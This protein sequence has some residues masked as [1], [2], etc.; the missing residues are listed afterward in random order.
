M[1]R[2][3]GSEALGLFE[4]YNAVY[5][6][7][8]LTE[9][10]VWEEVESWVN[11]LIEE[12]HDLSDYTW[13]EM[14][15]AYIVEAPLSAFS[16]LKADLNRKGLENRVSSFLKGGKP[17]A[18][19]TPATPARST[20]QLS[21]FSGLKADLARKGLENRVS[22]FLK[23]EKP[24]PAAR[25]D[26]T[27]TTATTATTRP[28][29]KPV[30]AAP[31]VSP[32]PNP[33]LAAASS[34]LSG[35]GALAAKPKPQSDIGAMITRSQQRQ[36]AQTP[37]PAA[38]APA[39]PMGGGRER[40]LRSSYEYDAYDLVLEYLLTEGHAD[41]VEEAH[42]VMMEMDAEVIQDIVEA[43][44]DQSDK[45]IDKGVKA[46]YKAQNVLDNQHQGRSKGLNKLPRGEREEKAKRMQGRLKTRRDDLFGERNKREDSKRDEL[47]KMLGL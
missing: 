40:M 24:V 27:A 13:E 14:Y 41:T 1:E 12:G 2:I 25:P 36:A 19:P 32:A 45:Q 15:E 30:T 42:Y 3:T 44:A 38:P 34:A 46:T 21:A 22:S 33:S 37:K 5:A 20:G 47:K 39:R 26:T 35:T 10:Q 4:A 16:G 6:P 8:E 11:S 9:E 29:A 18:T 23:G 31:K 17:T 7:Q 28:P 43:A